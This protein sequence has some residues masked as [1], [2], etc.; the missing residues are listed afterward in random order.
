MISDRRRVE[1]A[2]IPLV[3]VRIAGQILDHCV[4]TGMY[5]K[6]D[7]HPDLWPAIHLLGKA[8]AEAILDGGQIDRKA[9][10]LLR[11]ADRLANA[12]MADKRGILPAYR[13][14]QYLMAEL[15]E[16]DRLRLISGS[17][18]DRGY[19]MLDETIRSKPDNAE[20]LEALDRSAAKSARKVLARLEAE[21]VFA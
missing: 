18:F 15:L 12:V 19:E 4:E 17:D 21:G 10:K 6:P 16:S 7:D 14:A 3:F 8:A 2:V 1:L 9:R 11:R 5:A 20:A 13:H